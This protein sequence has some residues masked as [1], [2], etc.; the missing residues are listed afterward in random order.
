MISLLMIVYS[1]EI[2][3]FTTS[4]QSAPHPSDPH[5]R[6]HS[7]SWTLLVSREGLP[8]PLELFKAQQES[9]LTPTA[10]VRVGLSGSD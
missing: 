5:Q 6:C 3:S 7:P 4:F 10:P 9:S 2:F 1:C 8:K